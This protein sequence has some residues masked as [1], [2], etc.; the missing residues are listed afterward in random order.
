M[1]NL[2]LSFVLC[3]NSLFLPLLDFVRRLVVEVVNWWCGTDCTGRA[4]PFLLHPEGRPGS[5]H[6]CGGAL[7]ITLT[8]LFTGSPL[9]SSNPFCIVQELRKH[10]CNITL[11]LN[12]FLSIRN[13]GILGAVDIWHMLNYRT[14]ISPPL[15]PPTYWWVSD[16]WR[17]LQVNANDF[18]CLQM[19][20][21]KFI[22][23]LMIVDQYKIIQ[24]KWIWIQVN[25]D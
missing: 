15:P 24:T 17:W 19:F 4:A 22:W 6:H 3:L 23:I 11:F 18:R 2:F 21:K 14:L 25:A 9:S 5:G 8:L 12:C 20:L 13:L 1:N 16:I 10:E 7:H